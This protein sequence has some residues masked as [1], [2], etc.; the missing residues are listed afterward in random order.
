MRS[1][2][3]SMIK[4]LDENKRIKDMLKDNRDKIHAKQLE[5]KHRKSDTD[6]N[7]YIVKARKR[8]CFEYFD[9]QYL[10]IKTIKVIKRFFEKV[11]FK[12]YKIMKVIIINNMFYL[13]LNKNCK[14]SELEIILPVDFGAELDINEN[15]KLKQ[16]NPNNILK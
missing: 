16:I 7:N 10:D 12:D 6:W 5:Y 11:L 9:T 13:K 15:I 1:D 2:D 14:L 3:K 4:L 8:F